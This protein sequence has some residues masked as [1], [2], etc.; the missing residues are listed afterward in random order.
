MSL[1]IY[2]LQLLQFL[3]VFWKMFCP[4]SCRFQSIIQNAD[5]EFAILISILENMLSRNLPFQSM[6]QKVCCPGICHSSQ[7]PGKYVV[8]GSAISCPGNICCP[9]NLSI[10]QCLGR[11]CVLETA[12]FVFFFSKTS[13]NKLISLERKIENYKRGFIKLF[14]LILFSISEAAY[15]THTHTHTHTHTLCNYNIENNP[16]GFEMLYYF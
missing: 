13:K 8:P 1:K 4:G 5:P 14:L 3:S 16:I 2:C 10:C 6:S 9:G 15:N 7:C 12:K 11:I